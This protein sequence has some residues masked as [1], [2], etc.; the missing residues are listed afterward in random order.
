ML[1]YDLGF[2][3]FGRLKEDVKFFDTFCRHE[4]HKVTEAPQP[5]RRPAS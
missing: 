1:G 3:V 5:K 4:D 2:T